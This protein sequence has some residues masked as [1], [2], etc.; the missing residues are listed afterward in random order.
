MEVDVT[1]EY[2]VV[3]SRDETFRATEDPED[4]EIWRVILDW[5]QFAITTL[6]FFANVMTLITLY[7][8][9]QGF[10][11]TTLTLFRHQAFADAVVCLVASIVILQPFMWLSGNYYFDMLVCHIWHGQAVYWGFVTISTYNLVLI[12]YERYIS[13]C[14]PFKYVDL[15]DLSSSQICC[16][17]FGLYV[18]TL[19]ITHGTYIQTSLVDHECLNEYAVAGMAMQRYFTFFVIFTYITTYLI[20]AVIMAALYGLV[21]YTLRQRKKDATLS[22]SRLVDRAGADLTK[23]AVVVTVIFV[24]TIG[25]DLHYYLL[26]QTGAAIY[27]LNTPTQKVG[28]FLSNINSTCNPLVYALLMPLYR[29]S[30]TLTFTCKVQR[31]KKS[32]MSSSMEL[33]RSSLHGSLSTIAGHDS[34]HGTLS[35]VSGQ[36]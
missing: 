27:E 4:V 35:T 7:T 19:F 32:C 2:W 33:S 10:S 31:R 20:P 13:V 28:V 26:G 25:Y 15:E 9:S 3:T 8:N 22:H 23:T 14:K 12:A 21:A 6:G 5:V 1:T 24:I 11:K 18:F 16:R 30:L 17:Y 29:R 34:L 36:V